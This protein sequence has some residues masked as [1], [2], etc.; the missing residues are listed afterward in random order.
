MSGLLIISAQNPIKLD[1]LSSFSWEWRLLDLMIINISSDI[2]SSANTHPTAHV[3][4]A[5]GQ[6]LVLSISGT[7]APECF[8]DT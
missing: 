4:A 5:L 8:K 1:V 3:S 2:G 7:S 6:C